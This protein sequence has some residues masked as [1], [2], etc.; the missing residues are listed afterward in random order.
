ME[1]SYIGINEKSVVKVW[2]SKYLAGHSTVG[3]KISQEQMVKGIID[4]L[5]QKSAAFQ[6]GPAIPTVRSFVFRN[7]DT[8]T[9]EEAKRQL[10]AY[11]K[12][13]NYGTIP[14]KLDC[15][16]RAGG[17]FSIANRQTI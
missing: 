17:A 7:S 13:Y 9:F 16:E 3:N 14:I 6:M 1:A 4:I 15:V 11:I 5:D 10:Q 2:M 8:L 12:A